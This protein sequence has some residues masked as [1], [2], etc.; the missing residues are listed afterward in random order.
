MKKIKTI[1][2]LM[3]ALTTL[4]VIADDSAPFFL[5]TAK[6]TRIAKKTELISY[7]TEWDKGSSVRVTADG[8][9]L[10]EAVAPASGDVAW[11]GAKAS[12]GLHT[13]T[14]VSGGKTLTADFVVFD[15]D[16][17]VHRGILPF[18]QEVVSVETNGVLMV[19]TNLV[20]TAT[21]KADKVHLIAQDVT[22]PEWMTLDI[23]SG[24][25]VKF[26]PGTT[27]KVSSNAHC[28]AKGVIFTH[29]ND[30]TIG[31]DMMF[32]GGAT[33]PVVGE[34][35]ISGVVSDDETTE[36]RYSPPQ[37]LTSNISSDTR[38][39]GY[40]TYIV[41]NS[42]TVAS[43][44]KLTL[45]PGTILKFS[46]GCSLTVNGTLDA[47]GTRAAPIVFTSL[48]DDEH[49]GDTNGDGDKT[50]AQ[51]GDWARIYAGGTLNMNYCR[52]RYCNNNSDNGAIQG[53]GGMVTFDNSIIEASVYECVRMNSG[54]FISHNSI[55]RDA[56]M[57]FGYYGGS[58][59]YVYN[60]VV[61]DC[62]I[63]CR[64]SNKHF[65]NTVFYRCP[66]FLESTSSSCNNC[67]FYN[68]AGYGAQSATQVGK[69]GNIWGDPK[70]VDAENGDFRISADSPCVDAGDGSVAP[71]T[72]YYGQPRMD[73]KKIKDTG[74]ANAEGVCPD[75]GIY[76]VPGT[77]AVPVP[78]LAVVSVSAP[79]ELIVGESIVVE[80]VV[81][82]RGEATVSGIVRDEVVFKSGGQEVSAG[83]VAASYS[84]ASLGASSMSAQ[85]R[86]PP[87]SKGEWRIGVRVNRHRDI[88][89]QNLS[90]NELQS[91]GT[92]LVR[93]D[94]LR[95]G[96]S[97]LSL[98][99][100]EKVGFELLD[101]PLDG[102]YVRISGNSS[103]IGAA[104]G[105]GV[106][107]ILGGGGQSVLLPDGSQLLAVPPRSEGESAYV[108][109]GN[110]NTRDEDIV[111]EIGEDSLKLYG[112]SPVR[113]SNSGEAT[114]VVTGVGLGDVSEIRL[115]GKVAKK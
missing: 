46:S 100:D 3:V 49:G 96:A 109:V 69:N 15:N 17:E 56:S 29:V 25:V 36:Y 24:T 30:D 9:T 31:G 35:A 18:G 48:K 115:G 75:I 26:L 20:Y 94:G 33:Q 101:M 43:G 66:T 41:S 78:D 88:F 98:S 63:A 42:V 62:T 19:W 54:K 7:S 86:I 70:F 22:I 64:A 72:D 95:F 68:E 59:V 28:N 21:W 39:R 90:N 83:V 47:K 50:Y 55:F 103:A 65:Y 32:D 81:T 67:L 99:P 53:T 77:V 27:L 92:S 45:Q 91:V 84:L 57:G 80:Y 58:G 34:Y 105:V 4:G 40:R 107:P 102:G 1:I 85:I 93:M 79:V 16:V 114:F 110:S 8:A 37:T 104:V 82:N 10:K 106:V 51:G 71:E 5:N 11:D 87:L 61:A 73:V 23:E 44:A 112:V 13:L 38:L 76:E 2:A 12:K 111:V 108:V 14:H 97:N 74:I 89:E 113:A 60:G 6:G 52:I